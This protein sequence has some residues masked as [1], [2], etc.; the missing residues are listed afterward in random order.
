M[1]RSLVLC[2]VASREREA[3]EAV[4]AL[5]S[6]GGFDWDMWLRRTAGLAPLLYRNLHGHGILPPGVDARLLF[7]VFHSRTRSEIA[8][9]ELDRVLP[10]LSDAHVPVILLK[11]A[12]LATAIYGDPVLRPMIDLDLLVHPGDVARV[13]E[14]LQGLGYE[15]PATEMRP[16]DALAYS[17]EIG[18]SRPGG[19]E[20]PVEIHWGLLDSPLYRGRPPEEWLWGTAL[21]VSIGQAGAWMLGPEAQIL[22][23]CGHL[24]LHHAGEGLL[25]LNDIAEVL[26]HYKEQIDWRRLLGQAQAADLVLPLQQVLPRVAEGWQAPIPAEALAALHALQ[27]SA[28]EARVFGGMSA[29]PRSVAAEVWSDLPGLGRAGERLRYLA[30]KLFPARAYMRERYG[31]RHAVL[32]PLY[33]PYRW[34]LGVRSA[35]AF[36]AK[37]QAS[38]TLISPISPHPKRRPGVEL[39]DYIAAAALVVVCWSSAH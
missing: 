38:E 32:L 36:M 11:G 7:A 21:P 12:A 27:P 22:H 30:A 5:I 28:A 19:A 2:L 16:Q 15:P 8:F 24:A 20:I 6:Q 33:Y 35:L 25:W 14:A 18:L 9:R 39:Q 17:N 10:C 31:I 34:L 1:D 29:G 23:L 37:L 4:R 3:L 26:Y 13:L